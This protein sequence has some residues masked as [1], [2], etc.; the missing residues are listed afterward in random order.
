MTDDSGR[1]AVAWSLGSL[2]WTGRG[3][4]EM[5]VGTAAINCRLAVCCE[6]Q[7]RRGFQQQDPAAGSRRR[8]RRGEPDLTFFRGATRCRGQSWTL[9]G[10]GMGRMGFDWAGWVL[11]GPVGGWAASVTCSPPANHS[12]IWEIGGRAQ[13]EQQQNKPRASPTT[14]QTLK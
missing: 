9:L 1:S 5:S 8:R 7:C 2:A 13:D 4:G 10:K 14:A 12:S 6:F 3:V 11:G